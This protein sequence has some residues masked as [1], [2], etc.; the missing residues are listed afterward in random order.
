MAG[1]TDVTPPVTDLVQRGT[2]RARPPRVAGGVRPAV[3][4]RSRRARCPARTSRR[5]RWRRSSR[6]APDDE[7]A[8]R[9]RAFKAYE[10]EGDA[11][12]AAFSRSTSRASYG[13]AGKPAIAS[14]WVRRAERII[15]PD[16][17]TYVHGYLALVR[18]EAAIATGDID[19]AL[20][21]ARRAVE[22]GDRGIDADLR[23]FALT[24]LGALK[25]ATGDTSD[26]VAL[27][28][29]ASIAAV[30]G[31]LT[32]FTTG[33]HRVPDDRRVPGPDRLPAG[34]R[35]DRGD[36][37]LLRSAVALGVSRD[38]P[39]PSGGGGG[40][41][42]RLGAGRAGARAGHDR[43]RA[44][45]RPRR[46]RPTGSTPS[47]T[48][49][50]SGATSRAPRPRSARRTR[51]VGRRSRRS[52][53]SGSPR[54]RS[55]PPRRPSTPRSPTRRGT[56][57]PGRRLLPAQVEIA[58]AAGDVA[59]GARRRRRARRPSSPGYPSPALEAGRQVA[60]GRVLLAEGDAVGAAREL[61]SA[62]KG[63]REVGAPYEVARAQ[64]LLSRAL[65][66]LDDDDDADLELHAALD[67]FR[68]LGARTR[69]RGGRAGAPRRRGSPERAAARRAGRSCSPTSSARRASPRRSAT[70][71]GSASC[72]GTTTCCAAQVA[73]RGRGDRQ[74]DRRRVLRGLRVGS[75]RASIARSRS[76][77]PWSSIGSAAASRSPSGSVCTRPTPTGVATTT[78]ARASTSPPGSPRSPRAAR[79]SR[80]PRPSPRPARW[81]RSDS[82]STPVKGVAEPVDVATVAWS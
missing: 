67:E 81:R 29:E 8:I 4:G 68:R 15:G 20:E 12:R 3:P 59:A 31:E 65:R 18:S 73:A 7:L 36:R 13:Y 27:M 22:I 5:S 61:R 24:N 49:D 44:R 70:S 19:G 66:A 50:D 11:I 33:A 77:G 45:T 17:D 72:A 54:A 82:R 6:P 57:G 62:V 71:P 10:A 2:G 38:L 69:P 78:A 74:L 14:A 34:E 28:E 41:R 76:S 47:A 75:G 42:R 26:G 58:I 79:S 64:A 56:A 43:A 60:L 51:A 25:I 32:P 46:R 1:M 37:A 30:N 23:A 9:E 40:R 52:R 16:G 63:W 21:Q 35:V 80:R 55:R 53:S 39:D 48:S